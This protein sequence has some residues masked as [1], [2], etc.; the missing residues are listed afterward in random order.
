MIRFIF[1][2]P[3]KIIGLLFMAIGALLD[4]ANRRRT[5]QAKQEE[6][7]RREQYRIEQAAQR[8]QERRERAARIATEKANRTARIEKEKQERERQRQRAETFKKEQAQTDIVHHEQQ[9]RELLKLYNE[10]QRQYDETTA[11]SRK[12]ILFRKLIA[13]NNQLRGV[14]RQI[15]KAQYTINKSGPA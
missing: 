12:E 5:E 1:L 7:Q 2:L 15:E 9:R 6:R 14:D 4:G 3:I 13:I 8:E 10:L 11:D